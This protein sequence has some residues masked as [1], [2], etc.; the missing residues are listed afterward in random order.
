MLRIIQ[1][2]APQGAK[3]Y[4]STADYYSEG[5]ELTGHWRGDG[6]TRLGLAGT[7]QQKDWDALCDNRDP[8]TGKVLT[9]RQNCGRRVGYDFNFHVPKSVSVLYGITK[10]DRILEA[11]RDSVDAT[12][13]EM[14]AEM[15]TRVRVKGQ[16][17]DR[18]TGNMVWGEFVHATARPVDGV[19]DPHL[20]AHAFVFNTTWDEKEGRWKAGQFAGLK[21]D[22][23]YFEAVFHSRLARKLE[24]LGL[25]VERTKKGWEVAG[26]PKAA[27][28]KFSRRTALIED[29]AREKGITNA[30]EKGELGAKTRERKRKDLTFDELGREWKARLSP[31]EL[32]AL[33]AV[34]ARLGQKCIAEDDRLAADAVARAVEHSFERNSVVPERKL[35]TVAL[36]R[37]Y[38]AA[39]PK[40]VLRK[41][42]GQHLVGAER[43][44][45]RLV[46][47]ADVLKE[48]SRMINFARQ[49]RG[50]CRRL[51]DGTYTFKRTWL[52][53]DQRTAVLHVLNSPD[54]VVVVSGGAGTGKT[55]MMTEAV[56]AIEAHGKQVFTFAPSADAS[57]GVLRQ[58]G[59]ANAETV[60]RLLKDEQLQAQARG[61]VLWIDEAG[62]LG[63]KTMT[64]VFDLAERL[65]ARVILSGDRRQ[66]G[67]VE[68]GAALRLMEEEAGLVPAE[69]REIQRQKGAYKQAVQALSEGR[70]EEG[71]RQLDKLGWVREVT[72]TER[73]KALA[74]DYVATVA[75]G[76]TALV[77][78]PTHLEG[79]WITDEIRL[80]LKRTGRLSGGEHR[81]V[82]LQNANLTEAERRDPLNYSAGDV[83]VFH[84]NAKGYRKGERVVAEDDPVPLSE[85]AKFTVYHPDILPVAAGDILRVTRNG[86]T[87]DG[88][89][90]L[91][92]G[93]T[94]TVK[95]FDAK[96][97]IILTNGW[98]IARDFGHLAYGYVVTSHAS[99]GR[100]VDRVFIGESARSFPAASRQQF[101]VSVSRARQRATIY[102]DDKDALLDAVSRSDDRLSAT[103]F[104]NGRGMRQRAMTL[105]RLEQLQPA[106]PEPHHIAQ[107][108]Q[109][110]PDYDR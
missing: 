19:P 73:Y 90:R 24:E 80:K 47:T 78:S 16:N 12:M 83:L 84:Q 69:V 21:R 26:V 79:E 58:E 97:N 46:T 45:R 3:S 104:L 6:A 8:N 34:K 94:F 31:E 35:L 52:N 66:H 62:L 81:M 105:E 77:V 82:M 55:T 29:K 87:A 40:T 49:G 50:T 30:E 103:E 32:A 39:A 37:S 68:R 2:T 61:Q 4:Y 43:D 60:A 44:G 96:G 102:T 95:D 101:Y 13:R 28:E 108:E 88:E 51:G 57:R 91:N 86:S 23:P 15:Q 41:L 110:R 9:A 100:T 53:A 1:N 71:F 7:V 22:A 56:E 74:E 67:S 89:H 36:K 75:K 107:R 85:A 63:T 65:E 59:F 17:E 92:N 38:G 18:I 27:M 11:F 109:E 76:K 14:E 98:K 64:Q 106:V 54:R 33:D 93:A 10:D 5:Q 70:T 99:Q 42:A 48:E 20:H 25:P 72:E